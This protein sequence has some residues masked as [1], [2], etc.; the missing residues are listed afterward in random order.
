[1][2]ADCLTPTVTDP[3]MYD[4]C[5]VAR[6]EGNLIETNFTFA[7]VLPFDVK[8]QACNNNPAQW[9]IIS[10]SGGYLFKSNVYQWTKRNAFFVN[11]VGIV[12]SSWINPTH[13]WQHK[14]E[15]LLG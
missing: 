9:S 10:I 2:E 4:T 5:L 12:D 11:L 6:T 15:Q 8:W 3:S 14:G 13:G 7:N 1:M